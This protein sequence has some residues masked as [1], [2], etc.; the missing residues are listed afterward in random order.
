MERELLVR[1][2][3]RKLLLRLPCLPAPLGLCATDGLSQARVRLAQ[4]RVKQPGDDD[5]SI[6]VYMNITFN[7]LL[8]MY[9]YVYV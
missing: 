3:E 6:I 5:L 9:I 7:I 8:H 2:L 4:R 1:E